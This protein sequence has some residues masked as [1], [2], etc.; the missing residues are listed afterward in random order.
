MVAVLGGRKTLRTEPVEI[1]LTYVK[2]KG[3]VKT[4]AVQIKYQ[5]KAQKS[6]TYANVYVPRF[7][8]DQ[9]YNILRYQTI[10][11]FLYEEPNSEKF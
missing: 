3:R 4:C 6:Y 9:L 10:M 1:S 2:H 7:F 11:R 8:D 5:D